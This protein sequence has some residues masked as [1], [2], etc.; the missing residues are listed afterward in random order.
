MSDYC[1]SFHDGHV[2]ICHGLPFVVI[3][4]EITLIPVIM[5]NYAVFVI[6]FQSDIHDENVIW[7]RGVNMP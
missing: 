3:L 5:F 4:M 6:I 2:N 1:L 7:L